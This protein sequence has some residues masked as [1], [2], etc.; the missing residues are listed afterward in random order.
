[1]D[2]NIT[3]IKNYISP[4]QRVTSFSKSLAAILFILLPFIGGWIGYNYGYNSIY[5]DVPEDTFKPELIS[6]EKNSVLSVTNEINLWDNLLLREY[7]CPVENIYYGGISNNSCYQIVKVINNSEFIIIKNLSS[8]YKDGNLSL[9]YITKDIVNKSII[10]E[11]IYPKRG[12]SIVSYSLENNRFERNIDYDRNAGDSLVL[13]H[14]LAKVVSP[15]TLEVVDLLQN[16]VVRSITLDEGE[17]FD[18]HHPSCGIGGD[19]NSSGELGWIGGYL[20]YGVYVENPEQS[21]SNELIEF[22]GLNLNK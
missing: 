15:Q 17:I 8:D 1:M 10:F 6:N 19:W 11:V 22:R 14:F 18:S 21:C 9:D 3:N 16:K 20:V 2:L 13:T 12:E 7:S 5:L 4:L